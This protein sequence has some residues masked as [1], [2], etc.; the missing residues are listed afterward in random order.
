[1]GSFQYV[2]AGSN[3]QVALCNNRGCGNGGIVK[4]RGGQNGN[5]TVVGDTEGKKISIGNKGESFSVSKIWQ[6]S[7]KGKLHS[8][9][10]T[11]MV[12]SSLNVNLPWS[13]YRTQAA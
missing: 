2:V 9:L 12:S 11:P 5:S 1:M 8:A 7:K 4:G 6:W 10:D 13:D 3:L